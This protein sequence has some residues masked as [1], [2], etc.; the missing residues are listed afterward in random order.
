MTAGGEGTIRAERGGA[1]PGS[2][3]PATIDPWIQAE[4]FIAAD[5]N[6]GDRFG[7]SVSLSGE[8]VLVGADRNDEAGLNAGA[9]YVYERGEGELRIQKLFASDTAAGDAFG[10]SVS[11]DGHT[12]LVGAP[13]NDGAGLNAGAVYVFE[14]NAEG[15]WRQVAKLTASDAATADLFGHDVS[16]NGDTALV[17]APFDDNGL[18]NHGSAYLF[19]RDAGGLWA[20]V[21]KL[22]AS[23]A[24]ADD[25]FG[26]SVS[27]DGETAIVGAPAVG[28]N[29]GGAYVFERNA[30]GPNAWSQVARL[31]PG[32]LNGGAVF[33]TSVSIAGDAA[34]VGGSGVVS[35]G[36]QIGAA[37]VFER[38]TGGANAWGRVA[39]LTASDPAAFD[40][41]GRSVSISADTV[42][43]GSPADADGGNLAGAAYIFRRNAGGANVWGQ[44]E[45]LTAS[46]ASAGDEFGSAVSISGDRTLVGAFS[47][48]GQRGDQMGAVFVF[49]AP[50]ESNAGPDQLVTGDLVAAA[51]VA[52]V[53]SATG[54][55][56]PLTFQW[57][58][59]GAVIAVGATTTVRLQGFGT[60]VVTLTV[61]DAAGSVAT[62]TVLVA[63]QMPVVAGPTGPT[64][65]QGPQGVPGPPGTTGPQGP[66]GPPGVQGA[67]GPQGPAGP[68]GPTGPRGAQ[69][70]TGLQG[71]PGPAGP[72]GATGVQ[73]PQGAIGPQGSAGAT[74]A[75]GPQGPVG[76]TGPQGPQGVTGPTGPQGEGLF[77][78][79]LLL[80][81]AGSPAPAGYTLVGTFEMASSDFFRWRNSLKVDVYRRD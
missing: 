26:S 19:A 16:I 40:A 32:V 54:V 72:Q 45:Q 25:Q 64:G 59:G 73:G 15:L 49:T 20:Q 29:V 9:A 57:S 53:G 31:N 36:L 70:E 3:Y 81:P 5:G 38:H 1:Y 23:D 69:G 34:V 76:P 11:L 21:G 58:V 56:E 77:P 50:P 33:G 22:T 61:T 67:T 14:R 42:L 39:R 79:S 43:V 44:V 37:F 41:F 27:I 2:I 6:P 46:D 10:Q 55:R 4:Q 47:R 51:D 12:A 35:G 62:D 74:G 78:G 66:A 30:G 28:F 24:A 80:L 13:A 60:H 65:P 8:A 52:F 71:L 7:W 17:G 63:I 18:A 68:A 75:Q 48:A